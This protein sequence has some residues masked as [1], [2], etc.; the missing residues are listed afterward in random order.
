M[1]SN[2]ALLI[3]NSSVYGAKAVKPV[4][5][6][7]MES[8]YSPNDIRIIDAITHIKPLEPIVYEQSE[9]HTIEYPY[10]PYPINNL[11]FSEEKKIKIEEFSKK[12]MEIMKEK[13]ITHKDFFENT[14]P[15]NK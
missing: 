2:I 7:D 3:A 12:L 15:I 14:D 11:E 6:I 10:F 9:I 13:G 8:K 1:K 4:L 5:Y